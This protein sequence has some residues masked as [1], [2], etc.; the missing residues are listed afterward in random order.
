M[1]N[2]GGIVRLIG[3]LFAIIGPLAGSAFA[4]AASYYQVTDLGRLNGSFCGPFGVS[5]FA[6]ALNDNAQAAGASCVRLPTF[7]TVSHAVLWSEGA[8]S[9]LGTLGTAFADQSAASGINNAGQIVGRN[10]TSPFIGGTAFLWSAGTMTSLEP[11]LGAGF[12]GAIDINN[13]GQIVGYRGP[14]DMSSSSA[15][16]YDAISGQ[17]TS[18]PDLLGAFRSN[19]AAINDAGDAVGNAAV[20]PD[21]FHA[22]RWREGA[23]ADLGALGGAHSFATAINEAGDIV[24]YSWVSV[25]AGDHAFLYRDGVMR[26]LGALDGRSSY[27][28]GINDAGVIVGWSNTASGMHAFVHDGTTMTDL[29]D[30]ISHAGGWVLTQAAAINAAGQ[31]V[32]YGQITGPFPFPGDSHAFL[33]TPS[34]PPPDLAPPVLT[35]PADFTREAV[36]AEG[37]VVTYVASATDDVDPHPTVTCLPASGSIFP[38]GDTTVECIATDDSGKSASARFVVTVLPPFD[39][40][41]DLA[42]KAAVDLRAGVITVTGSVACN[43]DAF[44]TLY[45]GVS[46]TVAHRAFVQGSFSTSIACVAPLTTWTATVTASNGAFGAGPVD[47]DVSAFACSFGCDSDQKV[48]SVILVGGGN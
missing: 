1:S 3:T 38:V 12:S 15:F 37:V 34:E 31:I 5:T 33:L 46:E 36:S 32:G 21:V 26:D 42:R 17:V 19:A 47:A 10:F 44:V 30:M 40:G 13:A 7:Q 39:L 24:G 48:R 22:V 14:S 29:N 43:R 45:G 16:L 6:T 9:D 25:E 20:A 23:P 35:V 28:M 2:R 4:Q 11:V 41:I 27:A 18:L 8:I